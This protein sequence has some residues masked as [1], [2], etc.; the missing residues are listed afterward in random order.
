[1]TVHVFSGN[2][3]V[4]TQ[5]PNILQI[6]SLC[7]TGYCMTSDRDLLVFMCI[8]MV[9][10]EGLIIKGLLQFLVK[11]LQ[12]LSEYCLL[13]GEQS[14]SEITQKGLMCCMFGGFHTR[15][16][17]WAFSTPLHA[18]PVSSVQN[19][20]FLLYTN[21]GSFVSLVFFLNIL[22]MEILKL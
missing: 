20:R 5:K 11:L 6:V 16:F 4:F 1:M 19:N 18:D 8:Q 2:S 14:Q 12:D 21:E 22:C 10:W 3:Y 15:G 13:L 17:A 7:V 9:A